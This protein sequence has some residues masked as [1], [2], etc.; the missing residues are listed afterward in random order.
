M[1]NAPFTTVVVGPPRHGVVRHAMST[2]AM[3]GSRVHRHR[4]ADTCP[5]VSVADA[6][7]VVH[8]H[9]TD[10]L[11]GANAAAAATTFQRIFAD[12]DGR[13]VITLHDVPFASSSSHSIRRAAAYRQ[14]IALSDTIVVSSDAEA[15]RVRD[16]VPGCR[17]RVVRIPIR[18]TDTASDRA[19]V[20]S[21]AHS[22]DA[23][24]STIGIIGFVYPGKG[25]AD[26]VEAAAGLA[27]RPRV[28]AMGMPSPGHDHLI[29]HLNDLATSCGVAFEATGYLT[30]RG[31]DALVREVA[32]PVVA[33]TN[34]SA[35]AS[36]ATWVGAGRR[37]LVAATD[38]TTEFDRMSP[39][40]IVLYDPSVP[41]ALARLVAAALDDPSSTWSRSSPSGE[42]TVAATAAALLEL[43]GVS[44]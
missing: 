28:I 35:S 6:G 38:Y 2:A 13:L 33:S 31:M 41:G 40:T 1:S 43:S 3:V 7:D 20:G 23:H 9:Y 15:A 25:H 44:S 19:A 18:S 12:Y 37:P 29:T 24:R 4:T 39:D 27:V 5:H 34:T 30:D 17:V 26:V 11:F 10:Q 14:I 21:R 36:L 16:L 42:M 22:S 32:V 8:V